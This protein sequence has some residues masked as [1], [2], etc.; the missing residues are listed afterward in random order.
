MRAPGDG[1]RGAVHHAR[2]EGVLSDAASWACC[3]ELKYGM[4]GLWSLEVRVQCVEYR[5]VACFFVV[6]RA[7]EFVFTRHAAHAD[8]PKNTSF[9]LQLFGAL[10]LLLLLLLLFLLLL[11][12]LLLL[13]CYQNYVLLLLLLPASPAATFAAASASTTSL[14]TEAEKEEEAKQ[15]EKL[16]AALQQLPS[17][18]SGLGFNV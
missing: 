14:A 4:Y 9:L 17:C 13:L 12:R 5:G 10:L 2:L 1:T 6:C 7:A 8:T 11:L 18:I 16:K 3:L 15:S